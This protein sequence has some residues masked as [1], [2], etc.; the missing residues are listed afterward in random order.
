MSKHIENRKRIGLHLSKVTECLRVHIVGRQHHAPSLAASFLI[1]WAPLIFAMAMFLITQ[2]S[3]C[4]PECSE[5]L[6]DATTSKALGPCYV[7]WYDTTTSDVRYPDASPWI[8]RGDSAAPGCPLDPLLVDPQPIYMRTPFGTLD[9]KD[10][11]NLYSMGLD[12]ANLV[13]EGLDLEIFPSFQIS[14]DLS[15]KPSLSYGTAHLLEK[16]GLLNY[17][18]PKVWNN[19]Y[20][21]LVRVI[22]STVEKLR[23]LG[24]TTVPGEEFGEREASASEI[25]TYFVNPEGQIVNFYPKP[26]DPSDP[27]DPGYDDEVNGWGTMDPRI[28]YSESGNYK[29]QWKSNPDTGIGETPFMLF[30]PNGLIFYFERYSYHH[31]VDVTYDYESLSVHYRVTKIKDRYGN[32]LIVVPESSDSGR[33]D[34]V[35]AY[36]NLDQAKF[37]VNYEYDPTWNRLTA[38][39]VPRYG[40]DPF[41]NTGSGFGGVEHN[42]FE[43]HYADEFS[44]GLYSGL[45]AKTVGTNGIVCFE[46][47]FSIAINDAD[48]CQTIIGEAS[49]LLDLSASNEICSFYRYF[50]ESVDFDWS[51]GIPEVEGGA[52]PIIGIKEHEGDEY[53]YRL[54]MNFDRPA[55]FNLGEDEYLRTP[56][57][58][59]RHEIGEHLGVPPTAVGTLDVVRLQYVGP[60]EPPDWSTKTASTLNCYPRLKNGDVFVWAGGKAVLQI[61]HDE[62]SPYVSID[63]K[64]LEIGL[65]E[66]ASFPPAN[67]D[68]YLVREEELQRISEIVFPA[69]EATGG[70]QKR[71]VIGYDFLTLN[72][73][74]ISEVRTYDSSVGGGTRCISETQYVYDRLRGFATTEYFRELG[75]GF[76]LPPCS[77]DSTCS[78]EGN[79][80]IG[81]LHPKYQ[82][83]DIL[84]K[85]TESFLEDELSQQLS[86]DTLVTEYGGAYRFE[87]GG[88][89]VFD[90]LYMTTNENCEDM[91][92]Y[93]QFSLSS[94]PFAF[95]WIINP[96]GSATV[97]DLSPDGLALDPLTAHQNRY[98]RVFKTY[99][100]DTNF[101]DVFTHTDNFSKLADYQQYPFFLF[102]PLYQSGGATPSTDLDDILYNPDPRCYLETGM[103][104]PSLGGA[105]AGSTCTWPGIFDLIVGTT[106]TKAY[107][108]EITGYEPV[109]IYGYDQMTDRR[110]ATV[111][112][113]G[114]NFFKRETVK[115]IH[116]R[117]LHWSSSPENVS[118][119]H[120]RT[121]S[122]KD[123][124]CNRISGLSE[125]QI[126]QEA[127]LLMFGL[128]TVSDSQVAN[129]MCLDYDDLDI[130]FTY[131]GQECAFGRVA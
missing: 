63:P 122:I 13:P 75:E 67:T 23:D 96:D 62:N 79:A 81:L 21:E 117:A 27:F 20:G 19:T 127:E 38:I 14:E 58:M 42:T 86:D 16:H 22:P 90:A 120:V 68:V 116:G 1:P 60:G 64:N 83:I 101:K 5:P 7:P 66:G 98:S 44:R 17:G 55:S 50:T 114:H 84:R 125:S 111:S 87:L 118:N 24:D 77:L 126:A 4:E 41:I 124:F 10:R 123:L 9:P 3:F 26:G 72:N 69:S 48:V 36:N 46:P 112:G 100:F 88:Q 74:E 73:Q 35:Q 47:L 93:I 129:Q 34:Y 115:T 18:S 85:K 11:N 105:G 113:F 91:C 25:I 43:F 104:I 51:N 106:S 82:E 70:T 61:E 130:S 39:E 78:L 107:S 99:Q 59:Y 128:E 45:S 89:L 12:P 32:Y 8:W 121:S 76:P 30:T 31:P 119:Y 108:A 80:D 102:P 37:A 109:P 94:K 33:P 95:T 28:W 57:V 40:G 15:L 131:P 52:S 103:A 92:T 110:G 2:K 29:L 6:T 54:H 49:V 65:I 97:F 71:M 56:A 53:F